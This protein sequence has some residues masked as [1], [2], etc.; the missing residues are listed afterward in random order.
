MGDRRAR[1]GGRTGG[2]YCLV[3]EDVCVV[4]CLFQLSERCFW[5]KHIG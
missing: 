1:F 4:L 3:E 5:S 2:G